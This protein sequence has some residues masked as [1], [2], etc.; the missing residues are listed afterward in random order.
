MVLQNAPQESFELPGLKLSAFESRN[1]TA[2]FDLM[3]TM[4]EGEGGVRGVLEYNTD[5]F[6][7]ETISRM[8]GHL[9][10]LLE[11]IAADPRLNLSRLAM[12]TEA[13]RAQL[14]D[15]WNDTRAE[16]TRDRCLP[17]LFELQAERTPDAVCLR[18][19]DA[20]LTYAELESRANQL[21]H[22]LQRLGVGPESRVGILM[23]RSME[24][25]VALLGILKAGGAYVP[26]DPDFPRERLQYMLEDAGVAVLL[27]QSRLARDLPPHGAEVL[28]LDR[29]ADELG[30]ESTARPDSGATA[31]NLAYVI[32]TSGSTGRPKGALLQHR[33]VVNCLEWMQ[34]AYRLDESD[35]FLF[36][37]T[38]NFDP[39]VWE[40]FW[41]LMTGAQVV[42]AR[43][44]AQSHPASLVETIITHGAT[45]VYLVPS[46]LSLFLEERR[47]EEIS[48][49]RYVICGGESLTREVVERF[50]ERLPGVELHH[51]YGPTEATIAASET[52]CARQSPRRVMPIGR[53]LANTRLY[54]LDERMQP[55][56]SGVAG[57]LYIGGECVGRGYLNRPALTAERFVPDPFAAETGARLYRTGDLVRYLSDGQLEFTGRCD[58][59][60]KIRGMRIEPGEVEAVLG[61]Q[62]GVR[63]AA[64]VAHSARRRGDKRLVA[65][66]T[67]EPG[68]IL[69]AEGLRHGLREQLPEYMVPSTFVMLDEMPLLPSGKVDRRRL[70]APDASRAATADGY[71]APRNTVEELVAGIWAELLGVERVGAEDNFFDLGGHSLLATRVVSL[72]RE[73]FGV[74]LPVRGL[75]EAPTVGG[76]ARQ[77]LSEM[78]EGR[79]EQPRRIE[80]APRGS[81]LP[82]SF[83]QQRLWFLEQLESAGAAYH[84]P[85]IIRIGG[86]LDVKALEQ[87][88]GELVRRHETLRTT[89]RVVEGEP[90]QSIGPSFDVELPVIDLSAMPEDKRAAEA[91]RLSSE[92]AQRGFD[93]SKGP[94][95]RAAL[96]RLAE[97][98]HVFALTFHHIISD[99]WSMGVLVKEAATLYEAYAAGD[100]SPL[101]ELPLQYADYAV[102]QRQWLTGEV[103]EQQLSYWREQLEGASPALEL[104]TDF[105]RPTAQSFRGDSVNVSLSEE[106][107]GKLKK[108]SRDEG[109]TLFM[110]LLAAFRALLYR[111]TGQE[112]IAIGTPIANRQDS[113]LET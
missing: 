55:V 2:K 75:F 12:L 8:V 37:T 19:D 33:S 24:Q 70:P 94:L 62:E 18:G 93:L 61:E 6:E 42:V 41:P 112:E 89:F 14:L 5:L 108:L 102:W 46:M 69:S 21:A 67:P 31:Q 91:V 60:V 30:R 82:L 20:V 90:V 65:Y 7:A 57:E 110:T 10:M 38:L 111:S 35:R 84:I 11:S 76:M 29:C 3:L 26:L 99:G 53:P 105:T 73:M 16:F 13:E 97:E 50:H 39:S 83:A 59:Q 40:F 56:P 86:R 88:L 106:L 113:G 28:C 52:V 49:L 95:L 64:V 85:A 63:E 80:L 23:E 92:Q 17:E 1:R 15:G 79:L 96:L 81:E 22:H 78:R 27:T 51:S 74:E 43:P 25:A 32:Y 109:A 72:V 47:V 100:E 48:S 101:A 36:K 98:E 4:A 9:Q 66:V 104:P 58:E 87:T 107:T 68:R 103:L 71:V 77:I 54:V 34:R 44:D 45:V